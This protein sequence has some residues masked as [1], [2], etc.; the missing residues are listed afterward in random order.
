[1]PVMTGTGGTAGEC[2]TVTGPDGQCGRLVAEAPGDGPVVVPDAP[3]TGVAGAGAGAAGPGVAEPLPEPAQPA[4]S[5]A[6]IVT[7]TAIRPGVLI[8]TAPPL[9]GTDWA[10]VDRPPPPSRP[11]EPEA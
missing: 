9:A 10:G 5:V 3:G 11:A 7:A 4:A 8:I 1:M 6:A 2:T